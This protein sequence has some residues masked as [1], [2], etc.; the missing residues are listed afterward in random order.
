M[1]RVRHL[2]LIFAALTGSLVAEESE[3]PP[4]YTWEGFSHNFWGFEREHHW[5]GPLGY[6]QNHFLWQVSHYPVFERPDVVGAGEVRADLMSNASTVNY[7]ERNLDQSSLFT[8]ASTNTVMPI[9][10]YG[11]MPDI[12]VTASLP[13]L[14]RS[15]TWDM[16]EFDA[17]GHAQQR[18]ERHIRSGFGDLVLGVKAL[19]TADEDRNRVVAIR[20]QFEPTTAKQ[21]K[22]LSSGLSEWSVDLLFHQRFGDWF[23]LYGNVGET[24]LRDIDTGINQ[25]IRAHRAFFGSLGVEVPFRVGSLLV[26]GHAT[27]SPY[28]HRFDHLD[29][30][31]YTGLVGWAFRLSQKQAFKIG[32]DFGSH[33]SGPD[34]HMVAQVT[35][36]F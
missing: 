3:D 5:Y 11:L 24:F 34:S 18:F 4:I 8:D 23:T 32:V 19:L 28:D 12:E 16:R 14:S 10:R 20:V 30:T 29:N 13:Q 6:R 1:T 2:L 26:Q 33:S 36:E 9:V 35:H 21:T 7:K 17:H 31:S 27:E 15:G 22:L 25:A